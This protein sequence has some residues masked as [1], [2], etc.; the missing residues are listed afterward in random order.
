MS[1]AS[2]V[3]VGGSGGIGLG[4]VQRLVADGQRV[5]V[6]SRTLGALNGLESVT[7]VPVDLVT[8]EVNSDMLPDQIKG[9]VYCPG[10]LN[11]KP[12]RALKHDDFRNDFELNV[13]GAVKA[14]QAA[15]PAMKTAQHAGIVLFS[16][17]AV[18]Q[19]MHAHASI[20][21]SKG[22][23]EGLTRSLAAELSPGIRVNCIAPALTNTP[24]TSR[25]FS[26]EEKVAALSAKYALQRTG[27]ADDI[28]EMATFLIG[29][30]AG[31]ITGQII[32]VDG[33]MSAVRQ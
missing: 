29:D 12:F 9:L 31:W 14:I 10:T 28:A 11:L 32:G 13:I 21:A 8:D 2:F 22:A 20:A 18:A 16:T 26:S 17:V 6:L 23:I 27:T 25:F 7:H 5:T 4:I 15:L 33:G 30:K 1:E 3:V 19:G 24:L